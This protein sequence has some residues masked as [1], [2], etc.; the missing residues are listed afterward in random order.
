MKF[1]NGTIPSDLS[2]FSI[3]IMSDILC[4]FFANHIFV[5]IASLTVK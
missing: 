3:A 4:K 2:T 5:N 1:G